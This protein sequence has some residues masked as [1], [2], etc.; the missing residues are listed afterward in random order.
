MVWDALSQLPDDSVAIT[1]GHVFYFGG[2]YEQKI[3]GRF[4]QVSLL[5]FPNE[6][7]RDSEKYQ[8]RFFKKQ[9]DVDFVSKVSKDK[10][11]GRAESYILEVISRNLDKPIF[12]LQ[13]TFEEKFFTYLK[14]H[15]SP[16]GLWWKVER[17][18]LNRQVDARANINLLVNLKNVDVVTDDLYLRQQ[19]DDLLTY[20]VSYNSAGVYMASGGLYNEALAMFRKS[21]EVNGDAKNFWD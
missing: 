18:S 1:V 12:I 2:L 4:G 11:L 20:A 7:N 14:P 16:Y 6:K 9:A 10:K 5:Y 13:G 8:P 15:L 17:D 21:L 3:D 19:K